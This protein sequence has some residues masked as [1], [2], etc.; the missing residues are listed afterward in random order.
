MKRPV[1]SQFVTH[2]ERH[3]DP[4]DRQQSRDVA[5]LNSVPNS[6]INLL[7]DFGQLTPHAFHS[8]RNVLPVVCTYIAVPVRQRLLLC[9]CTAHSATMSGL[10]LKSVGTIN[11]R[12][13]VQ[14]K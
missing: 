8:L 10:N 3:T 6:H 9:A 7:Y 2:V 12:G 13:Y 4:E 14:P 11:K 5:N 1:S